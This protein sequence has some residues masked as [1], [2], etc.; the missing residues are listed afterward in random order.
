[1]NSINPGQAALFDLGC[2]YWPRH[3]GPRMWRDFDPQA[4]AGELALLRASGLSTVRAFCFWPDFMPTPDRVEPLMLERLTEFMALCASAS[5]GVFLTP[6]VGHMSG[7]NWPPVWLDDPA[8]L[9][10]EESLIQLQE[11]YVADVA[12][13]VA[14][15]PA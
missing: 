7:E 6:I 10:R 14:G 13:T 15:S 4:I 11:R 1:M 9:Y 8:R 5:V 2:N 3:T 12:R